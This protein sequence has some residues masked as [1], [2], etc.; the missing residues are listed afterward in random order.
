MFI[1]KRKNAWY[2]LTQFRVKPPGWDVIILFQVTVC[3]KRHAHSDWLTDV[4]L[5]PITAQK[6]DA[7]SNYRSQL[8]LSIAAYERKTENVRKQKGWIRADKTIENNLKHL[9]HFAHRYE[10]LH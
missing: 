7:D 4:K 3:R 6:M 9:K 8:K 10:E 1:Y 2:K 5:R